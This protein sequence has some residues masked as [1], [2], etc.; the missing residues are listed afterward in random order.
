MEPGAADANGARWSNA[1][2]PIP[3]KLRVDDL[4]DE[5]TISWRWF[6]WIVVFLV[7]F[8][9]GWNAFLIGWYALAMGMGEMMPGPMR[10][11]FLVFPLVHV[12]VGIGL[13]YVVI[14]LLF[15]R[16]VIHVRQ[17]ALSVRHLPFYVPGGR[18][19]SVDEIEQLYC[20]QEVNSGS[21]GRM[22]IRYPLVAQLKSGRAVSLLPFNSDRDVARAIEHLIERH[23]GIEPHPVAGEA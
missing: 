13:C 17:G 14:L 18:S 19:I 23:L 9:I 8:C 16:T 20:K 7:P 10:L 1:L 5:L 11:I 21:R 6:S 4:G 22:H 12:L 3:D 15:N 2:V